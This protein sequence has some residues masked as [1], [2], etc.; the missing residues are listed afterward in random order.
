MRV[1]GVGILDVEVWV[2]NDGCA[3][4]AR[5]GGVDGL[6]TLEVRWVGDE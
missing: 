6:M 2:T 1:V 3:R 4:L 5:D